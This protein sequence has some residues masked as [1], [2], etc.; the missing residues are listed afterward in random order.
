MEALKDEQ[1]EKL[2]QKI[3]VGRAALHRQPRPSG[4]PRREDPHWVESLRTLIQQHP[5]FGYRQLWALL[6]GQAGL[7]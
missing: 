1:I 6:R 3:G 4:P 7:W 5:T 2:K